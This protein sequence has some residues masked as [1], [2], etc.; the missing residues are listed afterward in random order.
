MLSGSLLAAGLIMSIL[1]V[2]FAVC[3]VI[4]IL[5]ILIQKGKGGG[6][7]SAF[8][9]GMTSGLLGSKTGDVLTWVTISVVG[10]FLFAA[11]ILDKWWKPTMSSSEQTPA[12]ITSTDTGRS[13]RP[14]SQP[15]PAA[16]AQ[17]EQEK[18][19]VPGQQ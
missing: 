13:P 6:L 17:P 9:G 11:L 8:A 4:L 2:L 15:A 18:P 3:C 5:V 12:P 14:A 19:V 1:A 7:S 10:V 16:P